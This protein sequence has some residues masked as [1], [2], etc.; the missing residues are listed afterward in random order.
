M[1]AT[2]LPDMPSEQRTR[3]ANMTLHLFKA[4]LTLIMSHEGAERAA[5]VAELKTVMHRYLE[6][7]LEGGLPAGR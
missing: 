5:Y 2:R 7:L 6:P 1:I 3:T 4:G